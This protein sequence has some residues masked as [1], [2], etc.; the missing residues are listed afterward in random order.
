M[1]YFAA[2]LVRYQAISGR[3]AGGC[4]CKNHLAHESHIRRAKRT[5]KPYNLI[6]II[7]IIGLER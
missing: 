1:Q 3:G 5:R 6:A 7:A 4:G 2:H